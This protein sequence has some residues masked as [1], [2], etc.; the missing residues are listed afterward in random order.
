MLDHRRFERSVPF[1]RI[2]YSKHDSSRVYEPVLSSTLERDW[3][4]RGNF[5]RT[6]LT[7]GR[8]DGTDETLLRAVLIPFVTINNHRLVI[9]LVSPRPKPASRSGDLAGTMVHESTSR[10]RWV[11]LTATNRDLI[12]ESTDSSWRRAK[13]NRKKRKRFDG[14]RV[15]RATQVVRFS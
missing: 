9:G 14:R 10:S 15:F 6:A 1:T 12:N 7:D 13:T 3:P 2:E 11:K 5:R 8:T 4:S